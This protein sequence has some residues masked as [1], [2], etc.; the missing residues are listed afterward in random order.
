[1]TFADSAIAF[2]RSYGFDGIDIDYEYATSMRDA[3]NPLD[4]RVANPRRAG[5]VRGYVALMKVLREKLD[6]ASAQDGK[7]YLLTVAA[8][9]SNWILRGAETYQVTPYLDY[10]NIISYDL[11]GAWNQFVGPNAALYDDGRD[12]ELTFWRVYTTPQYGGIGALN[13]DWSYHYFRG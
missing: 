8:T 11:H 4:W 1:N 2:L 5:L 13:T 9:A 12:A 7:Y 10:V 6:A 3:G